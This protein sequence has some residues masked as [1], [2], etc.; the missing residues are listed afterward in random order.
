MIVENDRAPHITNL[1]QGCR[2]LRQSGR[3][4]PAISN[5]QSLIRDPEANWFADQKDACEMLSGGRDDGIEIVQKLDRGVV[6]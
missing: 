4:E 3:K 1:R 2:N 6:V 5:K